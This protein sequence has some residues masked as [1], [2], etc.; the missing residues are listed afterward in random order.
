MEHSEPDWGR[1]HAPNMEEQDR[2]IRGK[3]KGV[4]SL[5]ERGRERESWTSPRDKI[6]SDSV[7]GTLWRDEGHEDSTE[8]SSGGV[9]T[10]TQGQCCMT[11]G[12]RRPTLNWG[13]WQHGEDGY[14]VWRKGM[15]R[16]ALFRTESWKLRS[17]MNLDLNPS[18]SLPWRRQWDPTP[19]LLPGKS[20]ER[21]S[22]VGCSP[23][24]R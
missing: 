20:H 15:P 13:G 3:R 10:L 4:W 9:R 17:W 2:Q 18:A 23:W 6:P 8:V 7:N 14:W 12:T 1:G 19:V 16:R 5:W 21:R 11:L 24:G 22:L